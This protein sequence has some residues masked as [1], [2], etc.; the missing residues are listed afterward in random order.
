MDPEQPEHVITNGHSTLVDDEHH[1]PI[2]ESTIDK[3]NLDPVC[4]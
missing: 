4:Q 1:Q 3:Q 2:E